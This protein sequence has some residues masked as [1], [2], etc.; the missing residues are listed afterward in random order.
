MVLLVL[1]LSHQ[2]CYYDVAEELYPVVPI[3]TN[4]TTTVITYSGHIAPFITTYCATS[5]ACHAS[6]A[7]NPVLETYDQVVSNIDRIEV[8]AITEGT[9]PPSSVAAPSATELDN[10]QA[11]IDA[12]TPNN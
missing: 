4:D 10:L 3:D 5:S 11:W 6:G 1:S 9:M 12:G 7:F 8:R 2:R